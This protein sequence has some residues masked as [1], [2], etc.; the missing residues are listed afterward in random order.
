MFGARL[1]KAVA[2]ARDLARR[3]ATIRIVLV[4]VIAGFPGLLD[5]IPAIGGLAGVGAKIVVN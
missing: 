2:A 5:P 4:P 1:D 3:E